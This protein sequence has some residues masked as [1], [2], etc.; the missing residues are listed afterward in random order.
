[1]T[2]QAHTPVRHGFTVDVEE[3]FHILESAEAPRQEAWAEA[4]SR[5]TMATRRLLDLL[6]AHTTRA[7]FFV[8]GW[9]AE[10]R[11]DL[12]REIAERG[13]HV[14]S[15][16]YGHHL[17]G[18]LGRDE[19][20]RDLDRSIAVVS[21]A[22]GRDVEAFRAPGFSVTPGESWV[23]ALLASR[24]IRI[25]AS[26][27]L[28]PHAHGGWPLDRT[29]PFR[30]RVE[31][32]EVLTETPAV[33]LRFGRFALPFSGGG[34]LRALPLPALRLAFWARERAHRSVVLHVHPREIDPDQPRMPLPRA[35]AFRYYVGLHGTTHKL[36]DLLGRHRF[37]ALDELAETAERDPPLDIEACP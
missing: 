6:D 36:A 8:L 13:H 7:T 26:L 15:H 4:P 37:C 16:G 31:G 14:G 17:V 34:Y 25:D 28:G 12:V 35:R 24:G 22:S 21:R 19:F 10:H 29:R 9:V 1:M 20:A 11:P 33:P 32:T 27:F 3:W 18:A 5:V 23:F 2:A 30:V